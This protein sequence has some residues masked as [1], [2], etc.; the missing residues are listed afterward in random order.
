MKLKEFMKKENISIEKAAKDLDFSYED[1]RRYIKESVIPRPKNMQKIYDWSGGVVQ[2]ND[3]Y[4][5]AND[6]EIEDIIA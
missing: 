5:S 4:L 2:P 3:F 1:I 6:N